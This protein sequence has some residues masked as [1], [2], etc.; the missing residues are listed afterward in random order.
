MLLAGAAAQRLDLTEK[1]IMTIVDENR[2]QGE[3]VEQ[4]IRSSIAT[5]RFGIQVCMCDM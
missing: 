2:E 1:G 5:L 3:R 4:E